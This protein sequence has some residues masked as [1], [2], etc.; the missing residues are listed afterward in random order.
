MTDKLVAIEE[1]LRAAKIEEQL[2]VAAKAVA[3]FHPTAVLLA[4]EDADGYKVMT[5]PHS[6]ALA[7]GML[8]RIIK[9]MAEEEEETEDADDD[10]DD[11]E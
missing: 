10:S 2:A 9:V 5:I 6:P 7:I 4:W 1:F 8:D 11:L 3:G